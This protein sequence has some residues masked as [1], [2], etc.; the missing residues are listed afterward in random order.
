MKKIFILFT[1]IC[2]CII[3]TIKSNK[4]DLEES[5]KVVENHYNMKKYQEAE[6]EILSTIEELSKEDHDHDYDQQMES[7]V[8]FNNET[9]SNLLC[10]LGK[11]H[12]YGHSRNSEN[13]LQEAF[14]LFSLASKNQNSGE[15]HYYLSL[16]T[17]YKLD[18]FSEKFS[19]FENNK[20][21]TSTHLS[22]R[23][24]RLSSIYLYTSALF[25]NRKAKIAQ[26]HRFL[27]GIQEKR[28]CI[29]A[30]AYYKD[31]A[32]EVATDIS[33]RPRLIKKEY[34]DGEVYDM[35]VDVLNQKNDS[36]QVSD[37]LSFLT[38]KCDQEESK[39]CL[40]LGSIYFYG[41]YGIPVDYERAFEAFMKAKMS[42]SLSAIN[43]VGIMYLY[44]FG[45]PENSKKA[46]E[47]FQEGILKG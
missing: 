24:K 6:N 3:S 43:N 14:I 16:M 40:R 46:Y 7:S 18:N 45:V 15:A 42:G 28:S 27:K 21:D 20:F 26:G 29:D 25:G 2:L 38:M 23:S 9:Y 11:I 13:L 31:I 34:L 47:T 10:T 19:N 12:F 4:I 35:Q 32:Y 37:I 17:F 1:S 22:A 44:G 33:V 5:F 36:R 30:I 8:Q 41:E 39:F